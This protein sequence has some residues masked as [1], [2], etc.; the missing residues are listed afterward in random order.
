MARKQAKIFFHKIPIRTHIVTEKDDVVDLARKYSAGIAAPGDFI[1]LAESVVAITQ[2]RAILP[3]TVRPGRLARFLSRFPGKDGSLAT[4]PAMQLAIEEVGTARILAGCAAAALGR[5]IKK[6][7]L[8]YIVAG[9]ELALID[10]IAGT[11]YPYERHIVMG[12]KNP[13]RLVQAIKKATGAEAVIA[14][15]NDKRCVDILGITDNSYR[16]AVIEALRDNPFGNEDEQ[17]P[18]VILKRR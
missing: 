2:G 11:M 8:F 9:R 5:L 14:D 17:T 18:I 7:G 16:Q 13:G 4:P 15:V 1:C 6:K 10:D 12:P 3:E